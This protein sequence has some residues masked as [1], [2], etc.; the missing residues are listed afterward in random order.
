MLEKAEI[1]KEQVRGLL[2]DSK[3]IPTMLDLIMSI[4]RLGL[5]YHYEKEISQLLDVVFSSGHDDN[6][7]HLVALR[8]YLLRK[9]RYDVSPGK[10]L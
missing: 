10:A 9:H 2:K 1:L 5:D 4:E 7:L 8:F 3:E 6:N